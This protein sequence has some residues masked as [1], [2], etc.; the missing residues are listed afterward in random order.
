MTPVFVKMA[1]LHPVPMPLS[2]SLLTSKQPF[3]LKC[4]SLTSRTPGVHTEPRC[5]CGSSSKPTKEGALLT[6]TWDFHLPLSIFYNLEVVKT[7]S[8]LLL[9]SGYSEGDVP[10][11]K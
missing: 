9:R 8:T 6:P 2:C 5:V 10:E 3:R 11:S 1:D 4:A 7:Q